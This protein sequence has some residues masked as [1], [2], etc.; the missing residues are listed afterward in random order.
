MICRFCID[1]T[2]EHN[3]NSIIMKKQ[4]F[5]TGLNLKKQLVSNLTKDQIYGVVAGSTIAAPTCR[6]SQFGD[7][8]TNETQTYCAQ[9]P[10]WYC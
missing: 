1:V 5:K 10:S 9:C 4:H 6:K 8:P 7:C 2:F 3:K